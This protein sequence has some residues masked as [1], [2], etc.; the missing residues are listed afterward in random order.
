VIQIEELARPKRKYHT[1]IVLLQLVVDFG[2]DER[3]KFSVWE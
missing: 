3:R 1:L 2:S